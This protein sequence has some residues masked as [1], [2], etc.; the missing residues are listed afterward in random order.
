[1]SLLSIV[2]N[3]ADQVNFLQPTTVIGSPE[4]TAVQMLAL[5][6]LSGKRIAKRKNWTVLTLEHTFS[7]VNGT[8]N[9]A[10]PSDYARMISNTQWDRTNFWALVGPLTPQQWQF[11][12]SGITSA[13]PRTKFR[14]RPTSNA[15]EFYLDPT[16]TSVVSLVFEYLSLNWCQSSGGTGQAAWAADTDT[17]I[18]DEDLLEMD[19]KWRFLEAKSLDYAEAKREFELDLGVEMANDGGMAAINI[20]SPTLGL[21]DRANLPDAGFG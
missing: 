19:L 20:F 3:V 16:P 2:Q 12:K 11:E 6:N 10:F 14:V 21:F 17:G 13:G 1:M 7:T 18:L 9:Y 5:A 15:K 8:A 4:E